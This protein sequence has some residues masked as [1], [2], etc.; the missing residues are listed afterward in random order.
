MTIRNS[1]AQEKVLE[2]I[3]GFSNRADIRKFMLYLYA[4][5]DCKTKIRYYVETL[6]DGKR[7]YL[8]R[9][10]ALNKGCDFRIFVEDLLVYNNGNDKCPSHNDVFCDL[11]RKKDSLS[12]RDYT[13]LLSAIEDIYNVRPYQIAE[14]RIT[15]LPTAQGWPYETLL[16][17]LRWLFIEQDITYW[18]QTGREMLM[19]GIKGV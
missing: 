12:V 10:T 16:K 8:E 18:A 11:K 6:A 5:E 13:I 2:S 14:S 19:N 9:P 1:G 17:L 7:I 4:T 15:L 3:D